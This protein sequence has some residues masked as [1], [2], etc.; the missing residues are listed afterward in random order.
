MYIFLFTTFIYAIVFWYYKTTKKNNMLLELNPELKEKI[1]KERI[2][3]NR[4]PRNEKID[5]KAYD[6]VIEYSKYMDKNFSDFDYIKYRDALSEKEKDEI[7]RVVYDSVLQICDYVRKANDAIE[8]RYR[9]VCNDMEEK[10]LARLNEFL[11]DVKD[12][13]AVLGDFFKKFVK[14]F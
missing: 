11:N 14:Y 10:D 9:I 8:I 1:K 4:L 13:T 3:F 7:H 6:S 2:L 12:E 5:R